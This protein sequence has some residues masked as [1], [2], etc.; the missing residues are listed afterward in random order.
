MSN[1]YIYILQLEQNKYYVGKTKDPDFR[2]EQHFDG[3][4]SEWTRKFKPLNT[5]QV[6]PNCD[7]YD[8]DKYTLKCM[9]QYG[10]YNV[11][12][13]SFCELKLDEKCLFTIKKMLRGANDK[14]YN[15]GKTGHFINDCPTV[16]NYCYMCPFCDKECES[17]QYITEHCEKYC[18]E[19][20]ECCLRCFRKGH[21]ISECH[22]K[23]DK[24]GNS[25]KK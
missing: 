2:L 12:G 22:A 14:C 15:C 3:N 5:I 23:T 1:I 13:G 24:Y 16:D 8:E 18:K 7:V 9:E 4:G 21:W 6:I 10:I 17:E 20:K 25:I 19:K 11:R